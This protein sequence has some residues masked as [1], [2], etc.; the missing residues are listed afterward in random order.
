MVVDIR[1]NGCIAYVF[2]RLLGIDL[3]QKKE[4]TS[5]SVH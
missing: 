5:P 2:F 3:K 4:I 1:V